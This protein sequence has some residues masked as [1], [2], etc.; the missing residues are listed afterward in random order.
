MQHLDDRMRALPAILLR[1]GIEHLY[2]HL[3]TLEVLQGAPTGEG[4]T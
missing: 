1:V 3:A 2:L 4:A